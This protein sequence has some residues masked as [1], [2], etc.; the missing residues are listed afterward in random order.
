M[1]QD[2]ASKTVCDEN[3]RSLLE[4]VKESAQHLLSID[5]SDSVSYLLRV[6]NFL[7]LLHQLP[8]V[9]EDRID[10]MA[11]Q[12]GVVPVD[13]RAALRKIL[14]QE[15]TQPHPTEISSSLPRSVRMSIQSGNG[16]DTI[17][18]YQLVLI[19]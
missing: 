14:R 17:L 16:N 6:P 2:N 10:S 18:R 7:D 11:R 15:V 4:L 19:F 5:K 9:V 3:Q 1:S 13:H 8:P 12:L